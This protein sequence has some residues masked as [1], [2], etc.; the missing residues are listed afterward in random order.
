MKEIGDYLKNKRLELGI[1]LENAEQYLKIRKKYLIA[2]EEGDESVLPGKT[3]FV[4]Y[5]RNYASYL[6]VDQK[7]INQLLQNDEQLYKKPKVEEVEAEPK[8]RRKFG[9]YFTPEKKKPQAARIKNKTNFFAYIKIILSIGI[10]IS[11]FFVINQYFKNIKD[12]PSLVTKYEDIDSENILVVE[13]EKSIEEELIEMA[14]ENTQKEEEAELNVDNLFKPL[15]DYKPVI[16]NTREPSWIKI[17]QDGEIVFENIIFS[18]EEVIVKA[19]KS[20]V[21]LTTNE[22]I[23]VVYNDKKIES[24]PANLYKLIRFQVDINNMNGNS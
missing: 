8:K 15:P 24:Q 18:S 2:I 3:Y 22:N 20:I 9:R 6:G 13:D 7:Y 4:G 1:S 21:L 10:L 12:S 17:I 11:I 16:V 19:D 14:E 23:K 5:L